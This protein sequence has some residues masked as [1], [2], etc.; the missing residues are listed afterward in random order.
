[1]RRRLAAAT[2]AS[3]LALALGTS[4]ALAGQAGHQANGQSPWVVYGGSSDDVTGVEVQCGASNYT[5]VSGTLDSVWQRTG[6]LDGSG[7]AT[8]NGHAIETWTAIDVVV[9]DEN[10]GSHGV[11][12]TRRMEGTYRVGS[13]P[14]I[15]GPFS[16]FSWIERLQIAGTPHGYSLVMDLHHTT[17]NGTC[18]PL[19]N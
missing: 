11:V 8:A 18:D 1:M 15:E 14:E 3:A 7:M 6:S 12:F 2:V 4:P 10:G 9:M 19:P 17:F 16:S 13:Y 5:V